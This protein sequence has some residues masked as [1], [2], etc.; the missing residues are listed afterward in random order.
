MEALVLL[1]THDI[2][3]ILLYVHVLKASILL[4]FYVLMVHVLIHK[5]TLERS[6]RK[7]THRTSYA[8]HKVYIK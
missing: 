8:R 5:E 4:R 2:R 6:G 1:S 3:N 7:L